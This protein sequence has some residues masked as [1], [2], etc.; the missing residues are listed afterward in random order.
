MVFEKGSEEN[1]EC[2]GAL[3]LVTAKLLQD[4]LINGLLGK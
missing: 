4:A 3:F 2:N 1:E